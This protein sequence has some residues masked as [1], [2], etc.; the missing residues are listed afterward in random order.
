MPKNTKTYFLIASLI[1][2]MTVLISVAYA[3]VAVPPDC[4]PGQT[5][6]THFC[7]LNPLGEGGSENNPFGQNGLILCGAI[8]I[9]TVISAVVLI[10]IRRRNAK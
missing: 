6:Q 1:F 4:L 5:P 7:T 9:V 10:K 3:D 8:V 2:T